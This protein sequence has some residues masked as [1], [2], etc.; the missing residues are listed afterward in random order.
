M[1]CK[2]CG[3]QL[4]DPSVFCGG[5]GASQMSAQSVGGGTAVAPALAPVAEAVALDV[6]PQLETRYKDGYA[7]AKVIIGI[8]NLI[9]GIGA[10]AGVVIVFASF[11]LNGELVFAG[12]ISG[13]LVFLGL[14]VCGVVICAQGQ[15]LLANLDCAVNGSPFLD[16]SQRASIMSLSEPP[17]QRQW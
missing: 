8:G 3:Q 4:A 10:I 14:F 12:V 15:L 2:N 9:K 13:A 1:H 11:T 17:A 16:N 5:C 6:I 7:A